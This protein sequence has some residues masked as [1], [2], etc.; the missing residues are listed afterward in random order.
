MGPM[1]SLTTFTHLKILDI[2]SQWLLFDISQGDRVL[3][4]SV[5]ETAKSAMV[6]L[7]PSLEELHV[8]EWGRYLPDYSE[9]PRDLIN[10]KRIGV[11]VNLRYAAFY[12]GKWLEKD[13]PRLGSTAV[14]HRTLS[15]GAG[16]E[17]KLEQKPKSYTERL[18]SPTFPT[19]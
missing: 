19:W 11:M 7:P 10:R 9:V 3:S 14:D 6:D 12:L 2:H 8:H 16:F 1:T 17:I 13:V 15:D 4:L 5:P 18:P